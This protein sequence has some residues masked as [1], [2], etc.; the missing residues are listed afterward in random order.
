[1][2]K[3]ILLDFW[4]TL[5]EQGVWSPTKQIRNILQIRMPFPEF[6]VRMEKAMMTS[7]FAE[8]KD[9]FSA[10]AE[11]FGIIPS[12]GQME[13]LIGMWNKNWML[14]EPYPETKEILTKLK[15]DHQLFL[16]ANSNQFSIG[17]VLEKF[18]LKELFDKIYLSY[19]IGYIKTDKLFFQKILEENNLSTEDCLVVGDS[20]Q[21]DIIPAKDLGIPTILVD[22]K[23]RRDFN[24][25]IH[26]LTELEQHL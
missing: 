1:M 5:V 20:I 3:T 15:E 24:P 7:P 6:V 8:L 13:K 26:N 4:G 17:N 21:S 11:E 9:A 2:A 22:R 19:E 14:A 18:K 16:I 10:I 25:K 12:K 23:D